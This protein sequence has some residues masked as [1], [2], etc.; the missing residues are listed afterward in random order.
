MTKRKTLPS[1]AV[2]YSWWTSPEGLKHISKIESKYGVNLGK[3]V[4][5]TEKSIKEKKTIG[6]KCCW[7][8]FYPTSHAE[9]CHVIPS[10]AGGSNEPSNLILMC[11]QCHKENPD[12]N[13]EGF[14]WEWFSEKEHYSYGLIGYVQQQVKT[15]GLKD[16]QLNA[17]KEVYQEAYNIL[18]PVAVSGRFSMATRKALIKKCV[19]LAST[20]KGELCCQS[21][22]EETANLINFTKS[23]SPYGW[24]WVNGELVEV[25]EQQRVLTLM[26]ELRE[27][28]LTYAE[29]CYHLNEKETILKGD[30]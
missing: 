21:L 11:D 6:K 4:E 14:F 24:K 15:F 13:D 7:A 3:L 26:R 16:S 30:P 25:P 8:C 19:Q 27:S 1:K 22:E 10:A 12:V 9:R 5:I 29:I 23:K 2:I 20:A 17:P 18:K 28:G